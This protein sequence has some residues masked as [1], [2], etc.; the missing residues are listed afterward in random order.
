LKFF[1]GRQEQSYSSGADEVSKAAE[2]AANRAANAN[3]SKPSIFTRIIDRLV[4]AKIIYE[5]ELV[6]K[7]AAFE[8]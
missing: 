6:S 3:S 5:D 7:S 4:P 2:A 8:S 1:Q